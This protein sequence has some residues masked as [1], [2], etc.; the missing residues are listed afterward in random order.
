MFGIEHEVLF[1]LFAIG[2]TGL[3]VFIGMRT[4][5]NK[6]VPIFLTLVSLAWLI[7]YNLATGFDSMGVAIIGIFAVAPAVAGYFLGIIGRLIQTHR[8]A[9]N[10]DR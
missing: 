2:V 9:N 5:F 6:A 8:K 1:I 10:I 7:W 4:S 3:W